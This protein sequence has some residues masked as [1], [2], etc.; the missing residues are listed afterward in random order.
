MYSTT[1]K[2]VANVLDRASASTVETDATHQKAEE[3][4]RSVFAAKTAY[5]RLAA[6]AQ[7]F[8]AVRR[9]GRNTS[10]HPV[11]FAATTARAIWK[12]V[13]DNLIQ[14]KE[15]VSVAESPAAVQQS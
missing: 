5:Q 7:P 15:A 1:A 14:G 6:S 11:V 4:R 2:N 12:H 8:F 10:I 3:D 9:V 13:D